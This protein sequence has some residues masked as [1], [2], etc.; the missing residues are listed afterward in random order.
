MQSQGH[1]TDTAATKCRFSV[2]AYSFAAT[3][4]DVVWLDDCAGSVAG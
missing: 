1:R 3:I 2:F 4:K